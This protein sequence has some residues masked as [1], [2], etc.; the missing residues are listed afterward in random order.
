MNFEPEDVK[1]ISFQHTQELAAGIAR[2]TKDRHAEI[3]ESLEEL[4]ASRVIRASR[5]RRRQMD[6]KNEEE[7]KR[8]DREAEERGEVSECQCCFLEY[9]I[10]RMVHCNGEHRHVSSTRLRWVG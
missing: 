8:R 10:F 4:Q 2:C 3:K 6:K 7:E 5:D 1:P 9:P